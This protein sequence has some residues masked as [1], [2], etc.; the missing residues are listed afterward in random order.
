MRLSPQHRRCLFAK[1]DPDELPSAEIWKKNKV[2]IV[3][4]LTFDHDKTIQLPIS[5]QRGR[6]KFNDASQILS[7]I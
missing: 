2:L 5:Y 7:Q 3:Q 1:N 6:D 4:T